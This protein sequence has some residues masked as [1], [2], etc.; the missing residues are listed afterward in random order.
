M[1]RISGGSPEI[2]VA[3]FG[4]ERARGERAQVRPFYGLSAGNLSMRHGHAVTF[5][6][7]AGS[8]D[9]FLGGESARPRLVL[10][11]EAAIVATPARPLHRDLG[12]HK[13]QG[14]FHLVGRPANLGVMALSG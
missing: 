13:R 14:R 12:S 4:S 7:F 6:T 10:D 11:H 1:E 8:I 5:V 3:G 2:Y 9:R